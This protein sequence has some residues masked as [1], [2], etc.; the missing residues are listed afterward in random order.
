MSIF[1]QGAEKRA[2]GTYFMPAKGRQVN[3]RIANRLSGVARVGTPPQKGEYV[4]VGTEPNDPHE[5]RARR[6]AMCGS[7]SKVRMAEVNAGLKEGIKLTD[8]LNKPL[9]PGMGYIIP[10]IAK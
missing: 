10:L 6:A 2:D 8:A 4:G 3:G 7:T 9:T 5:Q 1:L